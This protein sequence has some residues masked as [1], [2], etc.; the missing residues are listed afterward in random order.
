MC[1]NNIM[2]DGNKII[3]HL[4]LGTI[5]VQAKSRVRMKFR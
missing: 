2:N 4:L 1:H 5:L 3:G